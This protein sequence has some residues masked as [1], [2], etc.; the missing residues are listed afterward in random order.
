MIRRSL[1]HHLSPEDRATHAKWTRGVVIA[2][3]AAA[4]LLGGI[5]AAQNIGNRSQTAADAPTASIAPTD[6]TAR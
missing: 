4:L 5:I 6:R 3:G 1:R 2:Y